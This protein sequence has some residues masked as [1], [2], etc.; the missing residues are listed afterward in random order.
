MTVFQK[1]PVDLI[2]MSPSDLGHQRDSGVHSHHACG[3]QKR[4]DGP[5]R[6]GEEGGRGSGRHLEVCLHGDVG[7]DELQCKGTVSG[8]AVPGEEEGH[9]PEHRRQALGKTET[10][11]QGEGEVQHHVERAGG[12]LAVEMWKQQRRQE[13]K[14]A[15]EL[16]NRLLLPSSPSSA[17]RRMGLV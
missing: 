1:G 13:G 2:K 15:D 5:A 3:Q 8:S 14:S 9:E 6:G 7:Q 16:P 10:S 11:R 17:L 4:R 12:E